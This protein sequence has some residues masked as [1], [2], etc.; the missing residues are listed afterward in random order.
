MG[1]EITRLVHDMDRHLAICDPD[2]DVQPKDEVGA[3]NLLHIFDD[4]L[5]ALPFGD[6]L[7]VPMRKGMRAGGGNFHP[8]PRRQT[9]Q[10]TAQLDNME[11]RILHR[12]TDFGA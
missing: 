11:T 7:I 2:M 9:R 6:E 10:M 5:V 3:R 4:F 1:Q 8:A 12:L